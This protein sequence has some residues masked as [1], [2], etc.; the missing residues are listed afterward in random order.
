LLF[1]RLPAGSLGRAE[2]RSLQTVLPRIDGV[3]TT[4]LASDGIGLFMLREFVKINEGTLRIIANNEYYEFEN[5]AHKLATM[6]VAYPGT[7]IQLQFRVRSDVV[8]TIRSRP[9]AR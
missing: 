8:Y 1:D 7:M 9:G 4:R 2:D 5:G 3:T 6:P